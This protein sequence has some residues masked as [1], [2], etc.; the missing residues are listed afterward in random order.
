MNTTCAECEG[1]YMLKLCGV[2]TL[3]RITCAG[4]AGNGHAIVSCDNPAT[5]CKDSISMEDLEEIEIMGR[6][7]RIWK[8]QT[9][10]IGH[11]EQND[12][13]IEG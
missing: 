1:V 2:P 10:L 6:V 7:K 9:A 13:L 4:F 3:R 5:R 11:G 12:R 8:E